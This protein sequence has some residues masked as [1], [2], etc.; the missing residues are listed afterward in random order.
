MTSSTD[1]SF[2]MTSST[3][4]S[5]TIIKKN[6]WNIYNL[7]LNDIKNNNFII[8]NKYKKNYDII[9][10]CVIY[11]GLILEHASDELRDNYNI[12]LNA[13]QEN[14]NALKFASDRLK[15]NFNI[16]NEAIKQKGIA[17]VYASN[18]LKNNKD[19]VLNA[20]K[21]YNMIFLSLDY[22]LFID[23]LKIEDI[24]YIVNINYHVL[25]SPSFY[26][27]INNKKI[28][29]E[30]IKHNSSAFRYA[31][32]ILKN[33]YDII[34]EA[35]SKNG[36]LLIHVNPTFK[37]N[38]DIIVKAIQSIK[39]DTET[40][41]DIKLTKK[42]SIYP[43]FNNIKD[44]QYE[45]Y[46]YRLENNSNL[47]DND[48]YD[49]IFES[50]PLEFHYHDDVICNMFIKYKNIYF[51]FYY[52]KYFYDIK[53]HDNKKK[54]LLNI[55]HNLEFNYYKFIRSKTFNNYLDIIFKN[56]KYIS[57][58]TNICKFFNFL[59]YKYK[60]NVIEN[61]LII[62][63]IIYNNESLLLILKKH[64]I[65]LLSIDEITPDTNYN[66]EDVKNEFIKHNQNYTILFF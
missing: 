9:L 42:R 53:Y 35:V 13:V 64:D 28:M 58:T 30:I 7:I 1:Q 14:G 66:L 19:L 55:I 26:N 29:L 36:M 57:K 45:H 56:F 33:D 16:V 11:D 39:Q 44:S 50:I 65:L 41:N 17:I 6:K 31:S 54:I 22:K 43:D 25:F 60:N 34:M 61:M 21:N 52:D 15:N 23:N 12:V 18:E 49:S 38:L 47:F 46:Q 40:Y 8:L 4:Q 27:I 3:D 2:T 63:D 37:L 51:T 5:Y 59:L 24:L 20:F 10:N 32:Y 62:Q 48:N